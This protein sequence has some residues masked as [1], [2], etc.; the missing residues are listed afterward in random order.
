[1]SRMVF[2]SI[3]ILSACFTAGCFSPTGIVAPV[4]NNPPQIP[5][6]SSV[7]TGGSALA[8]TF[9][10]EEIV[11]ASPEAEMEFREGLNCLS[12]Y[13]QYNNSLAYF[14]AALA[15]DGNFTAAWL[16]EGVAFHNLQ[17]YDEAID[18]FDHALSITPLDPAIWNLKCVTLTNAGRREEASECRRRV[19]EPEP[20]N[21]SG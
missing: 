5:S 7:I 12:R 9:N 10:E 4:A 19:A 11:T 18:C 21:S 15:I 20:P 3:L 6:E 17:R 16:A 2:L 14:D 1:M 13:G 8:I